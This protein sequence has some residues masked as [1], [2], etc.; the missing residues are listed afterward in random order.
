MPQNTHHSREPGNSDDEE[1]VYAA[2]KPTVNE[3][4][5]SLGELNRTSAEFLKTDVETA[6]TF[7]SIA[8]QTEDL[9]KRQRN[10][11]NARKGYDTILR[12]ARRVRLSTDDEQFL[13]EKMGRL[14]SELQ[15]LGEV[16]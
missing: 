10:R 16:F 3:L 2:L 6:L 4:L 5:L 12:L 8:L 7:S 11:R 15:R 13:S 9:S 14:K 1:K